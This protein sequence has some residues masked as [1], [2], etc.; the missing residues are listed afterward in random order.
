MY[1]VETAE[2]LIFL[3]EID[4]PR[5]ETTDE[6]IEMFYSKD[7]L[8]PKLEYIL[9]KEPEILSTLPKSEVFSWKGNILETLVNQLI[10]PEHMIYHYNSEPQRSLLINLPDEYEFVIVYI[11]LIKVMIERGIPEK[12]WSVMFPLV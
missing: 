10:F 12:N 1:Q 3:L 11:E 8:F 5:R 4:K 7:G 9:Q 6:E 2:E